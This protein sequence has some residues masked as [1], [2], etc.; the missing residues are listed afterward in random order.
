MEAPKKIGKIEIDIYDAGPPEVT[1]TGMVLSR[2]VSR[3]RI[4]MSRSYFNYK[5]ILSKKLAEERGIN[6]TMDEELK[7]RRERQ[8]AHEEEQEQ[9]KREQEKQN[10]E[11]RAIADV[12]GPGDSTIDGPKGSTGFGFGSNKRESGD[13]GRHDDTGSGGPV[14]DETE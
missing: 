7:L 12:K 3:S 13:N 9:I 14:S 4:I 10:D 8:E 2:D 1:F 11:R 5:R 6:K